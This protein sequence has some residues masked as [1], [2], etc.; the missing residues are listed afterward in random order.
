MNKL[1]ADAF[2]ASIWHNAAIPRCKQFLWLLHRDRL[3]S[4]A[5]L[6]HRHIVESPLCAYCGEHEDQHHILLQCPPAKLVWRAIGW[7]AAPDLLD[8]RELW[9]LPALPDETPPAVRSAII[10]AILWNIWKA[11]NSWI[12]DSSL[13]SAATTVCNIA[14]DLRL[15]TYRVKSTLAS[16]FLR[17]WAQQLHVA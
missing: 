15:W 13:H 17:M 4:A 1:P 11:R 16:D 2:A 10:T 6:H 12:F 9:A 8:F 7:P 3:P 5:L 14:G